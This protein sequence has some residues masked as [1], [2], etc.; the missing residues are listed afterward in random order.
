[1][2]SFIEK[3]LRCR[4]RRIALHIVP[5]R[6]KP[7]KS[8]P[9]QPPKPLSPIR[10]FQFLNDSANSDLLA[11][12][13]N[14][15]V[16]YMIPLP[17]PIDANPD[18]PLF[19]APHQPKQTIL[20]IVN[21]KTLTAPT[22]PAWTAY[23]S[24]LTHQSKSISGVLVQALGITDNDEELLFITDLIAQLNAH[25]VPVILSCHHD[26]HGVFDYVSFKTLVG[27]I[28]ENA[29]ILRD[30]QRRDY[31]QSRRLREVITMCAAQRAVR[32]G[33][34]VGFHDVWESRPSA[35]VVCRAVKVARHFEAVLEHA[36]VNGDGQT[37]TG[38][39]LEFINRY[40]T[41]C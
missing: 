2:L 22:I 38:D 12:R 6:K 41:G 1:M 36:D 23:L 39:L 32:P 13:D 9:D 30:G 8:A 27:V 7:P 4:N 11:N 5:W 28:I 10:A 26:D 14:A 24:H 31:F 19:P 40:L 25:K 18:Q 16:A 29:C 3:L 15:A 20:G 33:F 37:N 35:A 21:A 34:F 17:P